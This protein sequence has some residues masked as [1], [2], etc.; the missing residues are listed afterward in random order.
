M[1]CQICL[2]LKGRLTHY[3][4]GESL[5]MLVGPRKLM[6]L[7]YFYLWA[8][9]IQQKIAHRR[10]TH[11]N[12]WFAMEFQI[13]FLNAHWCYY[14]PATLFKTMLSLF[15]KIYFIY[16]WL[17]WVFIAVHRLSLVEASGGYSLLRC[18]GFS[19]RWLLLLRSTGFRRAGFS[20]CGT[21]A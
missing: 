13:F 14:L 21:R 10:E 12:E 18:A 9:Q 6:G 16:F 5:P 20:T 8:C 4:D 3:R 11:E 17:R 7:Y 2:N 15:F 1:Y 19:L